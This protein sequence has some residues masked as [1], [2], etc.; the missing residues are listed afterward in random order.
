VAVKG[1]GYFSEEGS[2]TNLTPGATNAVIHGHS[3]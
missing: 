2:S 1:M 3:F